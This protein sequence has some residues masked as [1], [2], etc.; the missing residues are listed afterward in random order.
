MKTR[1]WMILLAA[2]V[3]LAAFSGYYSWQRPA[4]EEAPLSELDWLRQEFRLDEDQFAK[5]KAIH[6]QYDLI[7]ESLCARVLEA[8]ERLERTILTSSDL[9]PELS[10]ELANFSQVKE[11]CH[12]AMLK[13]VYEVAAVMAPEERQRYINKAKGQVIMHDRVR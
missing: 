7:C 6:A 3:G 5:V 12:R 11:N 8:Q 13:H 9:T 10:E 1:A 4:A 2:V